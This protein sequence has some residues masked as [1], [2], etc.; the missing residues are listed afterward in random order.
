LIHLYVDDIDAVSE[1]FGAPVD[2][3]GLAGRECDL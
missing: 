3:Q 2:E 1:E